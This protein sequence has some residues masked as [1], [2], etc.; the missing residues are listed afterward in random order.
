LEAIKRGEMHR[1]R[2]VTYEN[3]T[4]AVVNGQSLLKLRQA[5]FEWRIRQIIGL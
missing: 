4:Y 1:T 3:L 2:E 5:M